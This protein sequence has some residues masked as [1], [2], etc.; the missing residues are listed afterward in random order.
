MNK[1]N[2]SF[3][4]SEIEL[5]SSMKGSVLKEYCH[6]QFLYTNTAANVIQFNFEYRTLYLYCFTDQVNYFGSEEDVSALSIKTEKYPIVDKINMICFPVNEPIKEITV[7]NE[8]QELYEN[9]IKTDE[10][11]LTRGFIL[12]FKDHEISFEK[13]SWMMEEITVNKGTRLLEKFTPADSFEKKLWGD[14]I[15]AKC[16]REIITI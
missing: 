11:K 2:I 15:T 13:Y 8:I 16:R 9:Q 7:V 4:E 3:T 1:V 5:L 14:G 6:T 10:A 12:T